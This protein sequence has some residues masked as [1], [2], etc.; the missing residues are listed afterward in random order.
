MRSDFS[1]KL[2][3]TAE[4]AGACNLRIVRGR[5][6]PKLIGTIAGGDFKYG[7]PGT[8]SDWRTEMNVI[9]RLRRTLTIRSEAAA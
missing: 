3:E 6:H 7:F 4:A 9:C 1:K 2:L 8:P 5:K